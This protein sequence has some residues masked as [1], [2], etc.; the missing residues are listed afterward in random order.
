M[1]IRILLIITSVLIIS[2]TANAQDLSF[3]E[4]NP[5][6]TLVVPGNIVKKAKFPF[7]DVHGHQYRMA[8]QDLKPVI[9]AMDT[10]NLQVMVNLSGRTG[11]D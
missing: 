1:K 2:I 3:E 4:Y 6:S 8:T 5:K 7:I 9:T 11:A 10:L